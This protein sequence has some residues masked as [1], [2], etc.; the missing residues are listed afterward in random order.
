MQWAHR[1]SAGLLRPCADAIRTA[2]R[3]H[4]SYGG[5]LEFADGGHDLLYSLLCARRALG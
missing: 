4:L 1:A 3:T 2:A 5:G